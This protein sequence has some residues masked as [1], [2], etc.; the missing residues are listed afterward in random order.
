MANRLRTNQSINC[1]IH[2]YVNNEPMDVDTVGGDI[3][4]GFIIDDIV[5]IG[6]TPAD[7]VDFDPANLVITKEPND[8]LGQYT[9][10]YD[11]A[12]YP[13]ALVDNDDIKIVLRARAGGI[14]VPWSRTFDVQGVD[15]PDAALTVVSPSS[16]QEGT[17]IPGAVVVRLD[18][19]IPDLILSGFAVDVVGA[20]TQ[21]ISPASLT[22]TTLPEQTYRLQFTSPLA[23]ANGTPIVLGEG[24]L[25]MVNG[26]F[27][28][29][30]GPVLNQGVQL[31]RS[32][33]IPVTPAPE[34]QNTAFAI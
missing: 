18:T 27:E 2:V 34:V 21:R 4:T 10:F 3:M 17:E 23:E 20:T 12:N 31:N 16:V 13:R 29:A 25:I 22:V 30:P 1:P 8:G 33:L 9:G 5:L 19:Q 7:N 11:V 28:D 32:V 15:T 6:A 14:E 24:G 26:N